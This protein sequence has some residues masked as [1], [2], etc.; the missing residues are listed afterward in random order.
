[1]PAP[2]TFEKSGNAAFRLHRQHSVIVPGTVR[3]NPR[4]H[5]ADFGYTAA[6]KPLGHIDVMHAAI[7]QRRAVLQQ[8]LIPNPIHAVVILYHSEQLRSADF[9]IVNQAPHQL[10]GGGMP[11]DMPHQHLAVR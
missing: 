6:G 5:T 8:L 11:Q 4:R 10:I 7:H 2:N 9:S 1:M 3:V